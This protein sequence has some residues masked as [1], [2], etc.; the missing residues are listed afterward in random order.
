MNNFEAQNKET[1]S[2]SVHPEAANRSV[3]IIDESLTNSA[4]TLIYSKIF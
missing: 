1:T 2:A 3:P 4:S